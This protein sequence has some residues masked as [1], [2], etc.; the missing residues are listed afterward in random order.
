MKEKTQKFTLNELNKISSATPNKYGNL[1]II[2]DKLL[3]SLVKQ[4]PASIEEQLIEAYKN[5]SIRAD[6]LKTEFPSVFTRFFKSFKYGTVPAVKAYRDCNMNCYKLMWVLGQ[7]ESSF[8]DSDKLKYHNSKLRKW[9]QVRDIMRFKE[10][11]NEYEIQI[12]TL[13]KTYE[14]V[15]SIDFF[16]EPELK[17]IIGDFDRDDKYWKFLLYNEKFGFLDLNCKFFGITY[18]LELLE[19]NKLRI[20]KIMEWIS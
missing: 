12:I 1:P 16:N 10:T 20:L 17:K 5:C 3:V 6:S 4:K 8:F 19:K 13:S 7:F 2:D 14:T 11:Y 15:D 9:Q 18:K